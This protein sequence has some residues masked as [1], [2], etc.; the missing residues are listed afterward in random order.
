MEGKVG[1]I[2]N[3]LKREREAREISL[4][5]I[6]QKT[7]ISV[8]FLKAIENNEFDKLP[9]EVFTIGF[10]RNYARYLGL[11]DDEVVNMYKE[12]IQEQKLSEVKKIDT[13]RRKKFPLL[14]I[15]II[16]III[17]GFGS[18][19]LIKKNT[20]SAPAN[21]H[22]KQTAPTPVTYSTSTT[23]STTT[24]NSVQAKKLTITLQGTNIGRIPVYVQFC[25]DNSCKHPRSSWKETYLKEGEKIAITGEKIIGVMAADGG[26]V[27]IYRNGKPLGTLG[28]QGNV[29]VKFFRP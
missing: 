9:A 16:I 11:N 8:E 4:Q 18:I 27:L 10:I 7:K 24:T 17:L 15:I 21:N 26:K 29:K 6:S 2:G 25:S 19:L 1:D 13:T 3:Y 12:F 5:E 14:I 23:Y 28:K 20:P 22:T